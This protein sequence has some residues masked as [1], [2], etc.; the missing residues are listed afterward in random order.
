MAK[1]HL[2]FGIQNVALSQVRWDRLVGTSDTQGLIDRLTD[3]RSH[4]ETMLQKRFNVA[5]D[6]VIVE[7]SFTEAEIAFE[8]FRSMLVAAANVAD[9]RITLGVTTQQFGVRQSAVLT[10]RLDGSVVLRMTIFGRSGDGS[11]VNWGQSKIEAQS[12]IAANS[13]EWNGV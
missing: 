11:G 1:V 4:N 7:A 8:Q 10:I 6:A 2:Y 13:L 12:F 3:D 5:R 9:G